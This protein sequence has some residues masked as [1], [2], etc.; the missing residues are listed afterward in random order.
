MVVEISTNLDKKIFDNDRR[1]L[2]FYIPSTIWKHLWTE[3]A[4]EDPIRFMYY[5]TATIPETS[6]WEN[7]HEVVK[8]TSVY[9][10]VP[11]K[12]IFRKA[13]DYL[14]G[15]FI[16]SEIQIALNK[17]ET[18][19]TIIQEKFE[20]IKE[21]LK[22]IYS[23]PNITGIKQAKAKERKLRQWMSYFR[24]NSVSAQKLLWIHLIFKY[25]LDLKERIRQ[26]CEG[27]SQD[28]LKLLMTYKEII[29]LQKVKA[30][31]QRKINNA[32]LKF[33]GQEKVD[34]YIP[35]IVYEYYS[36]YFSLI[37]RSAFVSY[38]IAKAI[39]DEDPIIEAVKQRISRELSKIIGEK[40]VYD[41]PEDIV[42][43]CQEYVERVEET[44]TEYY[45][46]LIDIQE[47]T[48]N[49][50][51]DYNSVIEKF[52]QELMKYSKISLVG[53]YKLIDKF[54]NA[55]L[56]TELLSVV[57]RLWKDGKIQIVP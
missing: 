33:I 12:S 53:L 19:Y 25:S 39:I 47:Q 23:D 5:I 6:K 1:T 32:K 29:E 18:V 51:K 21:Q 40:V 17:G 27:L 34:T 24:L 52:E 56:R 35:K 45:R 54:N 31:A 13:I 2:K 55:E 42:H 37:D 46:R 22:N 4:L 15:K 41:I 28:T 8:R 20:E 16:G 7:E 26:E 14:K 57:K 3:I 30:E 50:Y 9:L 43:K 11:L 36:K 10:P 48:L 44:I 38:C 49:E